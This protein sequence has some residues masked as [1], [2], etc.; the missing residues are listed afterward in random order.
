MPSYHIPLIIA[1]IMNFKKTGTGTFLRVLSG[2]DA[3]FSAEF[4]PTEAWRVMN[5]VIRA[6]YC[7]L[8]S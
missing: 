6:L 8:V 3:R 1:R 5:S 2:F 4:Q 7:T